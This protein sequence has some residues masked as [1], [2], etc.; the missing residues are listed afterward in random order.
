MTLEKKT[1][2]FDNLESL[3]ERYLRLKVRVAAQDEARKHPKAKRPAP[4]KERVQPVKNE[5][6]SAGGELERF[7]AREL[8]RLTF[9]AAKLFACVV[10]ATAVALLAILFYIAVATQ[11]LPKT[12]EVVGILSDFY[13]IMGAIAGV[14]K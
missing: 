1:T 2:D 5:P 11:T 7:Q 3:R 10:A 8:A 4:L 12:T 14:D 6:T 9:F 13:S